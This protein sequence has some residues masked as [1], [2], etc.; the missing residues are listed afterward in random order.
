MADQ[1]QLNSLVL[2]ARR[3]AVNLVQV[4]Q[5]VRQVVEQTPKVEGFSAALE[6]S[7]LGELELGGLLNGEGLAAPFVSGIK[8]ALT[9]EQYLHD[10]DLGPVKGDPLENT[11]LDRDTLANSLPQAGL[12]QSQENLERLQGAIQGVT[13][14]FGLALLP[15]FNAVVQAL[16]PLAQGIS[17]LIVANPQ[18]IEGVAA[19]AAAF[20]G[21][22]VAATLAMLAFNATPIGLVVAAVAL[23]A[24]LIV[25][26]WGPISGFFAASAE[27][28]G[29]LLQ[30]LGVAVQAGW[31]AMLGYFEQWRAALVG[32]VQDG[33]TLLK[34]VLAWSPLVLL[35]QNW[36]GI[37]GWF[38]G[39]MA[40][41]Q[42][43][44]QQGWTQLQGLFAWSPMAVL[45]E[46][47]T[48]VSAFFEGLWG[49]LLTG[50]A[51]VQEA[52]TTLFGGS[53]LVWLQQQWQPV[54]DWLRDWWAS[55]APIIEPIREFF[56]GTFSAVFEAFGG[57]SEQPAPVTAPSLAT[58][59]GSALV[60]QTAEA[61][62]TSLD[63]S[64]LLRFEN[65]PPGLAL[66][67]SQ[68][69]QPGLS[70]RSNVGVR[71]LSQGGAT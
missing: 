64:L 45:Q 20:T 4:N 35:Y 57:S 36:A 67:D 29:V 66:A 23:A 17:R 51:P 48:P 26:Y 30:T 41:A 61:R 14:A 10:L 52:L 42:G 62:R 22:R 56:S 59:G 25:A 44:L 5:Q 60:Q 3:L 32:T 34:A 68:S 70:I 12:R 31:S 46:R 53:P 47:W 33:W 55:L 9:F 58:E 49:Q 38:A 6:H 18:L 2:D 8:A 40:Q 21:L 69:N 28:I 43:V 39:L 16:T 37:V 63:G 11:G 1:L 15:T 54:A 7:T 50:L 65:P 19:A 24:G 71:S 13:L 27:R